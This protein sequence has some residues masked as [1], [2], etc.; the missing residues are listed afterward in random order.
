MAQA[1]AELEYVDRIHQTTVRDIRPAVRRLL[2][3]YGWAQRIHLI[4]DNGS[5]HTSDDT[6]AFF[7]EL[8]PRIHVLFT[9]VDA[10][11]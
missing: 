1:A 8:S 6:L 11:G 9:P 10:R 4:I 2:H 3:P 5:S 7:H